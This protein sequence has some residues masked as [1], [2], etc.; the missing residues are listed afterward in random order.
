MS[1]FFKPVFGFF[2]FF[3]SFPSQTVEEPFFCLQVLTKN[4]LCFGNS[5][6]KKA[7]R[8]VG[9]F[10]TTAKW[11]PKNGF[12]KYLCKWCPFSG[13]GQPPTLPP[14]SPLKALPRPHSG[15]RR[16][17]RDRAFKTQKAAG[18]LRPPAQGRHSMLSSFFCSD[19]KTGMDCRRSSTPIPSG[20]A[21]VRTAW[22]ISG[23]S[24]VRR[25]TRAT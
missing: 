17:C 5:A 6:S 18:L 1:V 25:S 14:E 11:I 2:P 24:S 13:K 8:Q 16:D 23:A 3:C 21:P 20:K 22:T 10:R 7:F 9:K 4:V 15:R 19:H 12:E